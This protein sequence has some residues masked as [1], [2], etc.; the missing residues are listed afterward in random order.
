VKINNQP[1]PS[2]AFA[3]TLGSVLQTQR[4]KDKTIVLKADDH[5]LFADVVHVIDEC[6]S[7]GANVA[8]GNL[9]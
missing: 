1:I 3:L 6:H 4:E 2:N 9:E 5:L 7:A 8:L